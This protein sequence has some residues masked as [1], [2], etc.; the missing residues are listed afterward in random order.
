M[1]LVFQAVYSN[2]IFRK[3]ILFAFLINMPSACHISLTPVYFM[4]Q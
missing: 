3:I 4:I 1:S 2:Q